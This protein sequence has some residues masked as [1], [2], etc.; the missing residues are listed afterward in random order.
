MWYSFN[1]IISNNGKTISIHG[2]R[3]VLKTYRLWSYRK[4]SF[5]HGVAAARWEQRGVLWQSSF[6]APP[7]PLKHC[8]CD[9]VFLAN[10]HVCLGSWELMVSLGLFSQTSVW[11]R[12]Q[13]VHCTAMVTAAT[14]VKLGW[15]WFQQN[16]TFLIHLEPLPIQPLSSWRWI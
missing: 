13:W 11:L 4:Y 10:F 16:L 6:A 2:K 1:D 9:V 3:A 5:P 12:F 15:Q 14:L 7:C 8:L